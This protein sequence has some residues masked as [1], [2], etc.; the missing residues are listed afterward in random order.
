MDQIYEKQKQIEQLSES[1]KAMGLN[2]PD[3]V[4]P[5]LQAQPKEI[6]EFKVG[7]EVHESKAPS[8]EKGENNDKSKEHIAEE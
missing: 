6:E 3:V 7:K 8:P 2:I 5:R 1:L 4:S